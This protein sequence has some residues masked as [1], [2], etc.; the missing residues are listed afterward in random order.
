MLG[1]KKKV[2]LFFAGQWCPWCRAFQPK[3]QETVEKVK[4]AEP[5]DTEVQDHQGSIARGKRSH[6]ARN[7]EKFKVTKK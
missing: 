6:R 2:A 7:P 3:L 4:T 5:N 1:D